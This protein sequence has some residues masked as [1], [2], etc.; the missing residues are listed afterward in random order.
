[1]WRRA[2][3]SRPKQQTSKQHPRNLTK[4]HRPEEVSP[5]SRDLSV[6][7]FWGLMEKP[8][9]AGKC[10]SENTASDER[11]G[12][13]YFLKVS[14]DNNSLHNPSIGERCIASGLSAREGRK[15]PQWKSRT[16]RPNKKA[17]SLSK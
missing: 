2:R 4:N 9:P 7:S 17:K 6:V 3:K 11:I 15:R 5:E 14:N 1:L 10:G 8:A 13:K 12:K 16:K